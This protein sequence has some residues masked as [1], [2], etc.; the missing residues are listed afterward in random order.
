MKLLNN[1]LFLLIFIFFPLSANAGPV[2]D[3]RIVDEGNIV[4]LGEIEMPEGVSV[5]LPSG[6][7]KNCTATGE[8]GFPDCQPL[9]FRPDPVVFSGINGS[10]TDLTSD[11]TAA[12][13]FWIIDMTDNPTLNLLIAGFN[14]DFGTVIT[15]GEDDFQFVELYFDTRIDGPNAPNQVCA[16]AQTALLTFQG[17]FAADDVLKTPVVNFEF[18]TPPPGL[19]NNAL[20]FDSNN[21]GHGFDFNVLQ[22]GLVVYYYGH[23]VSGERLWLISESYAEDLQYGVPF[24]LDMYEIV[25]GV[26]GLPGS[27]VTVWGTINFT[28]HDCASGHA[29]FSGIDGDLEMDFVRLASLQGIGC[30]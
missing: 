2:F 20:F 3:I 25:E 1:G 30:E 12:S 29:A 6:P 13:A 26:F 9:I 21:S 7:N 11:L 17:C 24:E 10:S 8:E 19:E 22:G 14:E 16:A 4:R 18:E 5:Q 28:L 23:T 15:D 27:A